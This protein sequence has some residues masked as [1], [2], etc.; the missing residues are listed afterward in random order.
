MDIRDTV[1]MNQ[2]V[3]DALWDFAVGQAYCPCCNNVFACESGCT[4]EKDSEASS[5]GRIRYETMLAARRALTADDGR[6]AAAVIACNRAGDQE[7]QLTED[8]L[9]AAYAFPPNG[10]GNRPA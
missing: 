2:V 9:W 6:T 10:K 3:Y 5:E 1:A 8:E 7:R 4:I